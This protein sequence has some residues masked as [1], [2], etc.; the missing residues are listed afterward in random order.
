MMGSYKYNSNVFQCVTVD[1][2]YIE[3]T[4]VASLG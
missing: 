4:L 2:I 1:K 3:K